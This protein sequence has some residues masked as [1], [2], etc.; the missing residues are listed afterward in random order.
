MT[1][2]YR[3]MTPAEI[4]AAA[5]QLPD[6]AVISRWQRGDEV[7]EL[8]RCAACDS[9]GCGHCDNGRAHAAAAKLEW[10]QHATNESVFYG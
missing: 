7:I 10:E 1:L 2:P 5:S 4:R 8:T 3:D 9:R 6:G